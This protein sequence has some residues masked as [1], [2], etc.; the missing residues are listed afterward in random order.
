M[1]RPTRSRAG[2]LVTPAN[3]PVPKPL[4]R[5]YAPPR[6]R[7]LLCWW[8]PGASCG[9]RSARCDKTHWEETMQLSR[10]DLAAVGTLALAAASL[11][12]TAADAAEEEALTQAVDALRKAQL[13]QDKAKLEALASDQLS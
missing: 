9:R 7:I 2:Q 6:R 8:L 5:N 13:A 12:P 11:I 10:R 3:S 1:A 4:P